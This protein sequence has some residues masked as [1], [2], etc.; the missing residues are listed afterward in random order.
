MSAEAD[1]QSPAVL[2]RPIRTVKRS[3]GFHPDAEMNAIGIAI[4]FILLVLLLPLAPFILAL[5]VISRGLDS[6]RPGRPPTNE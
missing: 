4:G 5:W 6:L 2:R 1:Q 3:V